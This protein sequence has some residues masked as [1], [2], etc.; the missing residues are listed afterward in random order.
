MTTPESQAME[1][2]KVSPEKHRTI[3]EAVYKHRI[4]ARIVSELTGIDLE[5]VQ[6]AIRMEAAFIDEAMYLESKPIEQWR[7]TVAK[8]AFG[9]REMSF[10]E[11][12]EIVYETVSQAILGRKRLCDTVS[13]TRR[14]IGFN[15]TWQLKGRKL[16]YQRI[17]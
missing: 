16:S 4:P 6:A 7:I 3:V 1:A 5:T 8:S 12:K 9:L 11:E 15:F 17:G 13:K 14:A 2:K 10:G